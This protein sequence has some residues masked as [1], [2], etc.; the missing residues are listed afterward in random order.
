M[1]RAVSLIGAAGVLLVAVA[2]PAAPVEAEPAPL[3]SLF[4][5]TAFTPAD[6]SASADFDWRGHGYPGAGLAAAGWTPGAHVVVNG[7]DYTLPGGPHG[8]PD[9]VVADGQKVA[10]AGEG[11]A[12]GF[13]A[14]TSPGPDGD[15]TASVAASGTGTVTYSDG[16]TSA[17]TLEVP[18]W[19]NSPANDAVAAV[20]IPA[21]R[22]TG[23]ASNLVNLYAVT[24]PL[25]RGKTVTSVTLPAAPRPALPQT[26][27]SAAGPASAPALHI[28]AMSVRDTSRSQDGR[29]AWT[30]SWAASLAPPRGITRPEVWENQTVRMAVSPHTAGSKV[31]LRFGNTFSPVPV[32]LGR[33]TLATRSTGA[34]AAGPPVNVTFGGSA[35][36]TMAAGAEA[37]SDPVSLP[38]V[39]DQDLL[40][41]VYLPGVVSTAPLHSYALATSFASAAGSGDHTAEADG[42]SYTKKFQRWTLL[43]GADVDTGGNPGTVVALGDSQT[44]GAGSDP[45]T[46]NRWPD[47]YARTP[48]SGPAAPGVLNAGLNANRV[49]GDHR[50]NRLITAAGPSA[51][52]R[53]DRDVLSQPNVRRVV[54]YEG[55]NDINAGTS[56]D[57]LVKGID[58]IRDQA[59]SRGLRVTVATLP[60]YG[61][62]YVDAAHDAHEAVRQAVN[63]HIRASGDFVDFDRATRSAD[64]PDVLRPDYDFDELHLNVAGKQRLAQT[65]AA[66][67]GG[68]PV[69]MTQ[70]ASADFDGDRVADVIAA[71]S[72][73]GALKVWFGRGDGTLRPAQ[74]VTYGWK[75]T[76]TTAADFDGDGRADLI[77][78]DGDG[79]L[80][81]WIGRG[82][83]HFD[84]TSVALT[85]WNHTETA[86]GDFDGD[87]KADIIARDSAGNLKIWAGQGNGRFAPP[88]QVTAG[89]NFT[90]TTAAD[91]TGDGQ[92]DIIARDADNLLHLWVHDPRGFFERPVDVTK[93]WTPTQTSA[94]DLTGDGRAD[95]IARDAATGALK[96]WAGLGGKSFV[97]PR[98]LTVDW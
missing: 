2:S 26:C 38:V 53:L 87:M 91:F 4:D 93:G 40:V 22:T 49:V 24:V 36:V 21:S 64:A 92:A 73:S 66:G 60:P 39:A 42:G 3:G 6:G 54:L 8:R 80:N 10:L 41:S 72:R 1:V 81:I 70:T 83:G 7:T 13:L 71:D 96:I 74:H 44:D 33:V 58:A 76:E 90:E 63:A 50:E 65:L 89:W 17:Y 97:A 57:C 28:F 84:R 61:D 46:D 19:E 67:T 16:S 51:L 94:G 18:H 69:D 30:G 34:S 86:A 31:R 48:L 55:V 45:D 62:K 78:R 95:I 20:S 29:T 77:A 32:T 56:A 37:Y 85:G 9:N 12:L 14:A 23:D 68:S 88:R 25:S 47:L 98:F 27:P 75:F 79:N 35:S 15:T 43:T 11:D 5:N 59:E 52:H 82:D